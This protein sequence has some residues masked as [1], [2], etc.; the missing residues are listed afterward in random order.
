MEQI[1]HSAMWDL[2]PS[3]SC[4]LYRSGLPAAIRLQVERGRVKAFWGHDR[5]CASPLPNRPPGSL[6][7]HRYYSPRRQ[8]R[9][10]S[11][12]RGGAI[13][14]SSVERRAVSNSPV[15]QNVF[16]CRQLMVEVTQYLKGA[17]WKPEICRHAALQQSYRGKRHPS[18][19]HRAVANNPIV[20]HQF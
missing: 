5:R 18:S 11:S 20:Q 8:V 2:R 19:Y 10:C 3:L 16:R 15:Q 14:V 9:S 12:V 13:G 4:M 1:R 7:F 17:L 6:G